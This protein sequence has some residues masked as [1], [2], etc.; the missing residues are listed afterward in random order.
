[1]AGSLQRRGLRAA[2]AAA[3]L[4]LAA[5]CSGVRSCAGGPPAPQGQYLYVVH[6][7]P[8]YSSAPGADP[9]IAAFRIEPGSGA[10]EPVGSM[11]AGAVGA[12]KLSVDAGGRWFALTGSQL[13]LQRLTASGALEHATTPT[14]GGLASA[15]DARQR[16]FFL[17]TGRGLEVHA[18]TPGAGPVVATPLHVEAGVAP[19]A[20]ATSPDGATLFAV[21]QQQLRVY[22]VGERGRLT[23]VGGS[24]FALGV[25]GLGLA[26]HP[27]GRFLIVEGEVGSDRRVAVLAVAASGVP[28]PVAGSPFDVG[29]RVHGL[30][31][32]ADG[33]RAFVVDDDRRA[34]ETLGLDAS[35]GL[36]RIASTSIEGQEAGRLVVDATNRFLYA[37]AGK[38]PGLLAW[39]I[40]ANGELTPVA[41]APFGVEGKAIELAVTPRQEGPLQAAVLPEASS[42]GEAPAPVDLDHPFP[43]DASLAA[44]AQRLS[45]PSD[46]T[47]FAAILAIQQRQ[48]L[49]L[50]LPALVAALDDPMDGV[51]LRARHI[52]GPW[53]LTHPGR[54]DDEVL[55]WLVAG[56]TGRGAALDNASLT[57]LHALKRRGADASPYL[58][59]AL[60][61]GGQLRDEAVEALANFGPSAAPAVPELRRLLQDSQANRHAAYVLG[62]IGPRAAD[63]LPELYAL[64]DH[65][66]KPVAN[67]ARSAIE[68]IRGSR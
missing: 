43:A 42:F 36:H 4:A 22:A 31:L 13:G 25:R 44:I 37:T 19:L 56:K 38:P 47:R 32:S 45:D 34:I 16:Y 41:G 3:V 39:A 61:N 51:R 67:A 29:H 59:R 66:S 27:S 57:A 49:E 17:T 33:A 58:A 62:A 23:A 14:G 20:L 63:A 60:V 24:P 30:A 65:P 15:F 46:Q 68:R 48:D 64:I 40:E 55:G 6:D 21:D 35:G 53:A 12:F 11:A 18:C 28:E 1:M 7:P 8:G 9:R 2:L 50:I 54:V 26:V 10:L 5:A 52:L